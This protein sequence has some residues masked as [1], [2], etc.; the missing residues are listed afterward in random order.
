MVCL[1]ST[2]EMDLV[3]FSS[4]KPP[5]NSVSCFLQDFDEF[6]STEV[7]NSAT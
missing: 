1:G 7:S 2:S 4:P 3:D 6:T 5:P